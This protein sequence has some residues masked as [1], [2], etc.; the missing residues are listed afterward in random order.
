MYSY[1]TNTYYNTYQI[2]TTHTHTPLDKTSQLTSHETTKIIY[3]ICYL[4]YYVCELC[5]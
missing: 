2:Y 1:Y 5:S 4:L 3:I